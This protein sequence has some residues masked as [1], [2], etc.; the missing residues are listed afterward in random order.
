MEPAL[1]VTAEIRR[2]HEE[3]RM[4]ARFALEHAIE[5]G[6]LLQKQRDV[7][8]HGDWLPWIKANLPFDARTAENYLRVY[9]ER[10]FLKSENVSNLAEAYRTL[11]ESAAAKRVGTADDGLNRWERHLAKVVVSFLTWWEIRRAARF[12]RRFPDFASFWIA[13]APQENDWESLKRMFREISEGMPHSL[14]CEIFDIIGEGGGIEGCRPV[15]DRWHTWWD[16]FRRLE[17]IIHQHR[18]PRALL[19]DSQLIT[20][21]LEALNRR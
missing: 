7:T 9:K 19:P 3:V 20:S 4:H 21:F 11:A 14:M 8:K 13:C 1:D 5:L 10:D 6:A 16:E 12:P 2:L 15:T 18:P 17:A